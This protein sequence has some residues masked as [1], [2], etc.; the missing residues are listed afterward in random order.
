MPYD[1]E[2]ATDS[3]LV[4]SL[5]ATAWHAIYMWYRSHPSCLI[6][7]SLSLLAGVEAWAITL[8]MTSAKRVVDQR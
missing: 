7:F 3:T 2:T 5:P 6:P 8:A 1:P 4:P